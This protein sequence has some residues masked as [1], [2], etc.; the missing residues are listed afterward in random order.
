MGILEIYEELGVNPIINV[1]APATALSGVLLE[2]EAAD[3]MAQAGQEAARMDQL[4]GAAG[5]II[6]EITGAESA[7]VTA[8]AASSLTLGTAA[9]LTGLDIDRMER[10]PDTTGMPNEAIIARDQ[11]NGYDHAIRAAGAK[12]VEVGINEALIMGGRHVTEAHDYEAAIT[13]HTAAIAYFYWPRTA[14]LLPEVIGIAKKYGIPVLVDAAEQVPPV[15]NLR[16]FISM[17]ADLVAISGG[18]SIGGPKSSGIL[19]GRRDLIAAAALQNLD[20][21]IDTFDT[22][23]PPPSLIRKEELKGLPHNGIGRGFQV[24]REEIIGLITALRLF[25]RERCIQKSLRGRLLLERILSHLKDIPN[26]ELEIV[27]GASEENPATL[28]VNLNDPAL[29]QTAFEVYRKLT[30]G[31]P[32]IYTDYSLLSEGILLINAF[33]LNERRA[34]IVAQRLQQV[35]TGHQ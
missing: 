24:G 15:E 8:G 13:D 27:A 5:R 25:T 1:F 22:F 18:K 12:L 6:A 32:G 7:Y 35:I 3:A 29:G 4:Q 33:N 31:D 34:D 14:S 23:N 28:K 11:R 26:I 10:L 2:Q 20:L 9:C 16:K 17:G 21:T 30:E 19:C